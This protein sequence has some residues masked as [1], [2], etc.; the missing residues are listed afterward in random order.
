MIHWVK[1]FTCV[2]GTPD[3]D[4]FGSDPFAFKSALDDVN[5]SGAKVLRKVKSDQADTVSKAADP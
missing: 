2:N 1:D 4:E 3:M 5:H